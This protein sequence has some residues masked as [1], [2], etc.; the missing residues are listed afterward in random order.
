MESSNEHVIKNCKTYKYI[1][2]CVP[3]V[4]GLNKTNPNNSYTGRGSYKSCLTGLKNR[5]VKLF[6]NSAFTFP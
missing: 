6:I 4:P 2:M 5:A 3:F 1:R